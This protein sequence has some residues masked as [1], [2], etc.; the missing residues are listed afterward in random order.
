[1][2]YSHRLGLV[3]FLSMSACQQ[4]D[5]GASAAPQTPGPTAPQVSAP[6]VPEPAT[7]GEAVPWLENDFGAALSQAKSKNLPLVVDLWAPWCHTCL[8]MQKFVLTGPAIVAQSENFIWASVDTDLPVNA[9]AVAK[10]PQNFWPTFYLLSP[11]G[12]VLARHVGAASETEFLAFLAQGRD[13]AGNGTASPQTKLR[14]KADGA[15]AAGDYRKALP[16]YRSLAAQYGDAD[17]ERFASRVSLLEAGYKSGAYPE[18]VTDAWTYLDD[19]SAA[20]SASATDFS[21]LAQACSKRAQSSKH[22]ALLERLSAPEG[23]IRSMLRRTPSLSVDDRSDAMRVLR[24]IA[25][26]RGQTEQARKY[27]LEQHRVLEAAVAKLSDPADRMTYHWPRLEV[28]RWLGRGEELVE[29]L[30]A[31]TRALPKEY[32]PPY[33]LAWLLYEL[34]KFDEALVPAQQAVALSY[35]PRK[36]RTQDLLADIFHALGRGEDEKA[37]RMESVKYLQSISPSA[38]QKSA[39]EYAQKKLSAL[40]SSR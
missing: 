11:K 23:P 14:Q 15:A 2:K 35:G 20:S 26:E 4:P 29:E 38:K 16:L 3:F 5:T 6:P 39:L 27:A 8:S 28:H 21:Y 40:K 12:E 18:C 1:M 9:E 36:G 17:G 7:P 13:A 30:R 32:D 10:L 19:M 25:E 34:K 22:A 31:S 33:R 24:E 37:V